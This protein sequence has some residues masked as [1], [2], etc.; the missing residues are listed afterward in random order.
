MKSTA[1]LACSALLFGT[2]C[3]S[4]PSTPR[5]PAAMTPSYSSSAGEIPVGV[6][7]AATLSDEQ[8][9]RRLD[10]TIEYPTRAGSYPV[11][12]FSTGF[13]TPSRTYIGLSS[14]LA[15]HGYVVIKVGHPES[16]PD[17]TDLAEIWK[18]QTP[19]DWR[20]RTR[21]LSFIID[22]FAALQER[23]PELT[24]KLDATKVGVA[25]HSYGAFATMLLAG[26]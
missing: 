15:T 8:R 10:L 3:S 4:A 19:A 7:P 24:G 2:M 1:V 6:I 23:Y 26:A 22:S 25:G 18:N 21:D 16:R 20:N 11:I 13:G 14:Y 9:N 17:V 5:T 12:V